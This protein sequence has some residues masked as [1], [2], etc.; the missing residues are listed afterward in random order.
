MGEG[1]VRVAQVLGRLI[2]GVAQEA[3]LL[4]DQLD[5]RGYEMTVVRG[6]AG[7]GEERLEAAMEDLAERRGV[8][9]RSVEGM[10]GR[11]PRPADARALVNMRSALAE[12]RPDIL[13]TH[14]S[15][16]GAVGRLAALLSRNRPKVII[17]TFHGHLLDRHFSKARSSV[18]RQIER[19]LARRTTRIVAIAPEIK[20]DLVRLGIAPA[21][22]IEVLPIGLDLERFDPA[23]SGPE[24]RARAREALGLPAA[25]PV[26][27]LV[28]RLAR[29]KRV[30]RFL[31]VAERLSGSGDA[32]FLVVGTGELEG[33]L[34]DSPEARRLGGRLV[35]AG[36]R[37]DVETVYRATDALV[38]TS[39][40]EGTP[41]ALIEGQAAG[42]P[43][44]CTDIVGVRTVVRD[45]ETGL[46]VPP[47]DEAGLA[48]AV[49]RVL[50]D[51]ELA[52]RLGRAGR[53]HAVAEFSLQRL[54]ERWDSLYRRLLDEAG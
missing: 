40:I 20:D 6:A 46:L 45:G 47:E 15:K 13:H 27:T 43:V 12:L 18:F 30:D 9:L 4:A 53:K 8:R 11:A 51:R 19:R 14:A 50:S 21:D 39:E 33:E 24:D 28:G 7:P 38:S 17:H 48:D 2:S 29:V 5:G 34:R 41:I 37:D 26:V 1:D 10:R 36:Y 25:G 23:G 49:S 54:G 32:S 44:V 35:W 42:L 16:G 22:R 3:I 52:E 31:R